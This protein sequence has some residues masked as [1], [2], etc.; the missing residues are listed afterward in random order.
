MNIVVTGCSKGIG[1]ELV[2]LLTENHKVYGISRDLRKL[3]DLKSSLSNPKNFEFISEDISKI[4]LDSINNCIKS[5]KV[6]LLINNAGILVNKTFSKISY[7]DYRSVMDVNFWGAFNLTQL[8]LNKLSKAKGQVINI[9]SMGGI[10]YSSKFPG[11]SLYSSSKAAVSV[12]TECLAVELEQF[13]INVNAFAL[14]AVQTEMLND[15]FPEYKA[16]ISS[17]EMAT[18]IV[19]FINSSKNLVN[20]QVFRIANSNP[21][22]LISS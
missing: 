17:N 13:E 8:L 16:N 5:E 2:K 10:N 1:Y 14:G 6:D 9:S 7:E 11:L 15:A 18:F 3:K 12:L 19:N 20:G 22:V 4:S 21:W